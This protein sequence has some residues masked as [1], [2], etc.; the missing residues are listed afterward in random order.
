MID[1]RYATGTVRSENRDSLNAEINRRTKERDSATW[2]DFFNEAG[3]PA[4]EINSIDQVFADPQVKHLKMSEGISSEAIGEFNLV[5]QAV[6]LS[7]TPGTIAV[8]PPERGEHTDAVLQG[9]G[10][11]PDDIAELRERNIV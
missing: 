8:P 10:Y 9:L 6:K 7:R 5:A 3:V 4:G 2:I 1:E 11:S